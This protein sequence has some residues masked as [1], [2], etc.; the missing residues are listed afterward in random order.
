MGVYPVA[1]KVMTQDT[2][3]NLFFSI[4]RF[5]ILVLLDLYIFLIGEVSDNE[6]E[7]G[8]RRV[9]VAPWAVQFS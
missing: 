3:M 9:G 6:L 8:S 4:F 7:W 1:R 2:S 5:S